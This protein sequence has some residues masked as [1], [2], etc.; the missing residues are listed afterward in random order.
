MT[1]TP[2]M[3][4]CPAHEDHRASLHVTRA[5]DGRW[6]LHCHA[7]CAPG[8]VVAA[9]GLSFADLAP[10]DHP[11][12]PRAIPPPPA[13][14]ESAA[15]LAQAL[16]L[17]RAQVRRSP[18]EA[19]QLNDLIRSKRRVAASARQWVTLW[20]D[21]PAAWT[22]AACAAELDTEADAL[23]ADL[24]LRSWSSRSERNI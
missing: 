22:L 8:A 23:E 17:D 21:R 18:P 11:F 15:I 4:R 5:A 2:G 16:A 9:L 20:G 6:L 12:R 3:H 1:L 19:H 13:P 10:H 24:C 7:G 14:T